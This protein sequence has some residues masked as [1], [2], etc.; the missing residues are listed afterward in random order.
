MVGATVLKRDWENVLDLCIIKI[1]CFKSI[2]YRTW[3]K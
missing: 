2:D 1:K 3:S